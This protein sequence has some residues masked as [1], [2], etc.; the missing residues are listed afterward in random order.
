MGG[1]PNGNVLEKY[2][3]DTFLTVNDFDIIALNK[4]YLTSQI[5]DEDLNLDGYT[6]IRC[7]HPEDVSRGGAAVYYKSHLPLILKPEHTHLSEILVFQLKVVYRNPSAINS[8]VEKVNEFTLELGKTFHNIKE[9]NPYTNYLIGDL[10]EKIV[11]GG[12]T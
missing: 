1:L 5:N 6:L 10:N 12:V 4:T 8:S 7:D 2:L 3:L 11:I 9:K